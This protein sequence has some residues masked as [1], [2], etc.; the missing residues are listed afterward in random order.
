MK[1]LLILIALFVFCQSKNFAKSLELHNSFS[2][3]IYL[4]EY[5]TS[6]TFPAGFVVGDYIE[7]LKV[8]PKS[9][10][11]GYYEISIAYTRGNIAA[12]ATHVA[13]IS[14]A[15]PALWR[16]T[17]RINN[18]P[19]VGTS[20]NFTID[21]NTEAANPR[22][23]IRAINTYGVTT[24]N[25]TVY[26]KVTAVNL[27]N[28]FTALNITGNDTTVTKYLPM[29]SDWDLYVGNSFSSNGATLA[30]KATQN[31]NIGIGT[32][33]PDEKLTVKGKIHTQEVKVDLLGALV[34]DY[35]FENDYQL[36]TLEEVEKYIKENKHLPEI[37]SAQEI[38][39][40][41]LMLAE[42]NMNLLKKIEEMTLYMIEM[43]KE[44]E[45]QNEEIKKLKNI[46]TST[47][48]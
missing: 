22:F 47:T 33:I 45:K 24:D 4:A 31:G 5:E 9:L 36:K 11:G 28:S 41:G 34:P 23:R 27:N 38:E 48:K 32:S 35:V 13:A 21:C 29:T 46:I 25:L 16:E 1:K 17:G 37:P 12:A 42:M 44:N 30:M 18:N 14:H 10:A 8:S 2:N 40:N 26:I 7:F 39:K 15:N 43:K 6:V 3:N 20:T 19:Y